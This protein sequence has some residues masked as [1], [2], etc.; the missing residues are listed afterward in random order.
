MARSH[1]ES[2]LKKKVVKQ[3]TPKKEKEAGSK[4]RKTERSLEVSTPSK[5]K[6]NSAEPRMG[7]LTLFSHNETLFLLFSTEGVLDSF[8]SKSPPHCRFTEEEHESCQTEQEIK[9]AGGK[10]LTQ[11]GAVF[12]ILNIF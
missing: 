4:W 10:I 3:E 6:S 7:K 12:I 5:R 2:A 1:S 8:W 11:Y 9:M